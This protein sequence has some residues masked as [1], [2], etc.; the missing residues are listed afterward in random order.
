MPRCRP[1]AAPRRRRPS[2]VPAGSRRQ[3]DEPG[4]GRLPALSLHPDPAP[5]NR[6][7]RAHSAIEPP[8]STNEP[9][10]CGIGVGVGG[11]GSGFG[12]GRVRKPSGTRAGASSGPQEAGVPRCTEPSLAGVPP[13]T[14]RPELE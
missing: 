10:H 2:T 6:N 8:K 3:P 5:R 1:S 12:P 13:E 7:E 14:R 4:P 9:A 11:V